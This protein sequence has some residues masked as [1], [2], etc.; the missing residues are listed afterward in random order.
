MI[1]FQIKK[2][3]KEQSSFITIYHLLRQTGRAWE[4]GHVSTGRSLNSPNAKRNNTCPRSEL[5]WFQVEQ[6]GDN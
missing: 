2:L 3:H 5:L 6:P 4:N 1:I